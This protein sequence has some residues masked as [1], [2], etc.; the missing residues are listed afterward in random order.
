MHTGDRRPELTFA[1][2]LNAVLAY[3]KSMTCAKCKSCY[4]RQYH[5]TFLVLWGRNILHK[6]TFN[7]A[8][9]VTISAQ[10]ILAISNTKNINAKDIVRL[11]LLQDI[12]DIV[13]NIPG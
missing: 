1:M 13:F 8:L 3:D 11:I 6:K 10:S 7:S 12:L 5:T 4:S 2:I 9:Q